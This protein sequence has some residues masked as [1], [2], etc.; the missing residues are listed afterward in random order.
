M[1]GIIIIQDNS[2]QKKHLYHA[3]LGLLVM[4]FLINWTKRKKRQKSGTILQY[5]Y[6]SSMAVKTFQP[7]KNLTS[8]GVSTSK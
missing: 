6:F 3:F 7:V 2:P 5:F 1:G 4:N 8:V